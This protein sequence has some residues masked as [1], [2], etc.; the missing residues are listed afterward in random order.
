[1]SKQYFCTSRRKNANNKNAV[2]RKS[3][4][5]VPFQENISPTCQTRVKMREI[6]F[7]LEKKIIN[8][9]NES[10]VE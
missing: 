6:L 8:K 1:M 3:K 9:L 4:T 5:K 7:F 2:I 10:F